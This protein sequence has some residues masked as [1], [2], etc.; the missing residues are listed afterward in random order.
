MFLLLLNSGY[1]VDGTLTVHWLAFRFCSVHVCF[2]ATE[3]L[4]NV[5]LVRSEGGRGVDVVIVF[6]KG[7]DVAAILVL[8]ST[9][10]LEV[11]RYMGLRY[12]H[13]HHCAGALGAP[14][15]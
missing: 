9:F 11:A 5:P 13:T 1:Q 8:S 6:R 2:K 7:V 12:M 14:S 4:F 10:N 3:T 15:R